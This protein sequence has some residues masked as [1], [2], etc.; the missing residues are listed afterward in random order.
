VPKTASAPEDSAS[1]LELLRQLA[2]EGASWLET[3]LALVRAE[4][5]VMMRRLVAGFI[6]LLASFAVMI[7]A[8]MCLAGAAVAALAPLLGGTVSAALIVSLALFVLMAVL[9]VLARQ[10]LVTQ[11]TPGSSL[12]TWLRDARREGFTR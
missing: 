9:G 5:S 6:T 2:H 3:E 1:I 4:T 12:T 8:V 11:K 7:V 10:L